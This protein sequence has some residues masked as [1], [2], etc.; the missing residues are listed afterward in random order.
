MGQVIPLQPGL[1]E[2]AACEGS[3]GG[4]KGQGFLGSSTLLCPRSSPEKLGLWPKLTQQKRKS[5]LEGRGAL[6]KDCQL[7]APHW[8]TQ[9]DRGQS[10][11][12]L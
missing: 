8:V 2:P 5:K 6:P 3:G 1:A 7:E 12:N 10:W 4:T 11:P 9:G